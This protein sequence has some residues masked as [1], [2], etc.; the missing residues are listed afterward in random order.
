MTAFAP[1]ERRVAAALLAVAL[2]LRPLY[3]FRYRVDTDE[4]QHLHVAWGWAHGFVQYRDL[5]DNHM[6][7]F[8][9]LTAPLVG[10]LGER[11]D[12]VPLMRLAMLPCYVLT[13]WCT[14]RIGRRLFSERVG[15][16]A[17]V[18]AALL[19]PFFRCSLEFRADDL[20]TPLWLAA[21]VIAVEGELT[22]ARVAAA[23][24]LA[25]A[26]IGVS[27]KTSLLLGTLVLATVV[28]AAIRPRR[29][30]RPWIGRLAARAL[31]FAAAAALVPGAIAAGFAAAGAWEPFVYGTIHHNVLPSVGTWRH[32]P[33][34]MMLFPAIVGASALVGAALWR[35]DGEAPL[36][37]R[38]L[39]VLL[40]TAAYGGALAGVWP[41]ISREDYLPFYPVLAIAVAAFTLTVGS[42][43]GWM[44][45]WAPATLAV[46]ELVVQL[47]AVPLWTDH[48]DRQTA[49]VDDVLRLTRPGDPVFDLKGET[50]FRRRASYWVF[51]YITKARLDRGL[52]ADTVPE[53]LIATATH[54]VIP[55]CHQLTPRT[56]QFL[57]D[58]YVSVGRLR[59]AGARLACAEDAPRRFEVAI[60]GSYRLIEK[61]AGATGTDD[62]TGPPRFEVDG[63]DANGARLLAPGS[64]ELRTRGCHG[65]VVLVWAPAVERGFS[66]VV[67]PAPEVAWRTS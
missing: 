35:R 47:V 15:W 60:P 50:I 24:L 37:R 12:I 55:D 5:F 46:L 21:L 39:A 42:G 13:L 36:G 51:E 41:V 1:A 25:G 8:H 40:A 31:V 49:F 17:A 6:P 32:G 57:S 14:Y 33:M 44:R 61:P 29:P 22:L 56:R 63:E 64:H 59:V 19:P 45:A 10:V 9:L 26:A 48:A 20:W 38:R 52:I 58:H 18:L 28:A 7:L 11:A 43:R 27:M 62:A 66:P 16:W 23:G 34:R 2:A 53:E 65:S 67:D 54:V 3:A 30:L 4:P